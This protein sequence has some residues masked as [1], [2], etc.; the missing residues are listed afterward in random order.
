MCLVALLLAQIQK[1]INPS[2]SSNFCI[3]KN[4]I[5][6]NICSLHT[7]DIRKLNSLFSK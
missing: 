3:L 6:Y 5:N 4:Y 2:P 7:Q 1:E